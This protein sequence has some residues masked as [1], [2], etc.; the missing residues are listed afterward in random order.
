MNDNPTPLLSR[1]VVRMG[2]IAAGAAL[3]TVLVM[4]L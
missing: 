3:A 2:L 1:P 4:A